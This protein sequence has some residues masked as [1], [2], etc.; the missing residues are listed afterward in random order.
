MKRA[1]FSIFAGSLAATLAI[2]TMT[3]SADAQGNGDAAK[4][5]PAII[6]QGTGESQAAPDLAYITVGVV[7]QGK[8]AQETTQKNANLT[9]QVV[10]AVKKAGIADKD[11]Q[12]SGYSVQPMYKQHNPALGIEG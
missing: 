6:V 11:I 5:P 12:T 7:S 2:A 9:Q 3:T 1:Y 8:T 4:R 10:A